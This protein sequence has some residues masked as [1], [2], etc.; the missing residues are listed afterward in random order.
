M[1]YHISYLMLYVYSYF[2]TSYTMYFPWGS[3]YVLR[4]G[5][6]QTNPTLGMGIKTINP[7]LEERSSRVNIM[8]TLAARLLTKVFGFFCSGIDEAWSHGLQLVPAHPVGLPSAAARNGFGIGSV[9]ACNST[10]GSSAGGRCTRCL[11]QCPQACADLHGEAMTWAC[12]PTSGCLGEKDSSTKVSLNQKNMKHPGDG[13]SVPSF[14]RS[15]VVPS[16]ANPATGFCIPHPKMT[17]ICWKC[18]FTD[19]PIFT[20]KSKDDGRPLN[21]IS[22]RWRPMMFLIRPFFKWRRNCKPW[23]KLCNIDIHNRGGGFKEFF[24]FTVTWGRWTH[25]DKHM[26]QMGWNHQLDNC[27]STFQRCQLNP[28]GWLIDTL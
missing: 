8:F 24:I 9:T 27:T 3:R 20:S 11:F 18:C 13:T 14:G 12:W 26:F 4:R 21:W 2:Y 5:F 19:F 28:K 23:N 17:W 6:P 7:I 10:R 15:K 22:H 16:S 1:L 25:F